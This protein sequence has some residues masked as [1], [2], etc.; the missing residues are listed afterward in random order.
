MKNRVFLSSGVCFRF[1]LLLALLVA[2]LLWSRLGMATPPQGIV[3][4]GGWEAWGNRAESI[5][6][7]EADNSDI[8][9]GSLGDEALNRQTVSLGYMYS[10][11]LDCFPGEQEAWLHRYLWQQDRTPEHLYL[12]AKEDTTLHFDKLSEKAQAFLQGEPLHVM[13]QKGRVLKTARFPLQFEGDEALVVIAAQPFLS[14]KTA[15]VDALSITMATADYPGGEITGWKSLGRLN[16]DSSVTERPPLDQG[17]GIWEIE[18]ALNPVAPRVGDFWFNTGHPT[19]SM[20]MPVY[21]MRLNWAHKQVL[22]MP[23]LDYGL[24]KQSDSQVMIP[25]WDWQND[26]NKD[27]YLDDE[28]FTNRVNPQVSSRY[29]SQSRL[30][31][32]GN[33]WPGT[34]WMRTNFADTAANQAHREWYAFDW[35]RQGLSGAYNDDM[36]KLLGNNQFRVVQGGAIAELPSAVLGSD[37][38][39]VIYA[40]QMA[41]FLLSIKQSQ[42][43]AKLAANISELNLWRYSSWPPELRDVFDVWLREHYLYAG[44][45]IFAL[46]QR[47]E[48]FAL[49][50]LGDESLLM[51]TTR[52]SRSALDT[53]NQ[54]AWEMDIATGL[55]LYYFFHTPEKTSYHSWNQTFYYG[56]GPTDEHNWYQP[57]VPKNQAYRPSSMLSHDLGMPVEASR[58]G[59]TSNIVPWVLKDKLEASKVASLLQQAPSG[60]FGLDVKKAWPWSKTFN[61]IGR[62]FENGL[63][64]YFAGSSRADSSAWQQEAY[65]ITLPAMYQRVN[66]DGSLSA[67]SDV[68][69]LFPYEG[70][71]FVKPIVE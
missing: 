41:A 62:E 1:S 12:H 5:R 59:D 6:Q 48:H 43:E 21:V 30:I 66:W 15:N 37:E 64:V 63:V 11:K 9:F 49:T 32:L 2:L 65:E 55:A 18:E 33:M 42:P 29:A 19:L 13:V 27:G 20:E 57:G 46:Q 36:A 56:S 28:E 58:G 47:W 4:P 67:P 31:P 44:M 8:V 17:E 60:W 10:Q 40:K 26:R 53:K 22:T 45:G 39:A 70:A 68:I 34:C 23:M 38:A 61:A 52:F 25:G 3:L 35:H 50:A 51:T 7:W 14:I 24:T 54:A 16:H 71:I 69:D